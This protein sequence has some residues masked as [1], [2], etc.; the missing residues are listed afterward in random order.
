MQTRR[1]VSGRTD[2]TT[3]H[4]TWRAPSK[5]SPPPT[6]VSTRYN[7][8][9]M[10]KEPARSHRRPGGDSTREPLEGRPGGQSVKSV[11][12]CQVFIRVPRAGQPEW[13]LCPSLSL[14]LSPRPCRWDSLGSGKAI[15]DQGKGQGASDKAEAKMCGY[16]HMYLTYLRYV[17][18]IPAHSMPSIPRRRFF[19]LST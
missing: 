15:P 19:H 6:L 14:S 5:A 12:H 11:F 10:N 18:S 13:H 7:Q 1:K 9:L 8:I 4:T 17:L 3:R 16:L 2:P